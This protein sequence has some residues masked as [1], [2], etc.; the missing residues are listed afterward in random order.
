[1]THRTTSARIIDRLGAIFLIRFELYKRKFFVKY[2]NNMLAATTPFLFYL[3]GGYL[4]LNG[5]F[6]TVRS[7][8]RS[9]PTRTCRIRSSS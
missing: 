4:A 1:M 8:P 7:W 2:L 6:D 9:T 3:I 5:R